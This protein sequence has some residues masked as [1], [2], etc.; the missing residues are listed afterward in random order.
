[1]LSTV[2]TS[3]SHDHDLSSSSSSSLSIYHYYHHDYLFIIIIISSINISDNLSSSIVIT[4]VIII[5]I[6]H[7]HL[8]SII[9]IHLLLPSTSIDYPITLMVIQLGNSNLSVVND[10][11]QSIQSTISS[12]ERENCTMRFI[13]CIKVYAIEYN[14]G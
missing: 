9:I 10:I 1:M 13:H 11:L 5:I 8:L 2:L 6:Y 12:I 14:P 4:L 3:L 7:H